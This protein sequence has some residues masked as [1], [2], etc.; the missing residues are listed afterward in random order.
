[1]AFWFGLDWLLSC[2]N[3]RMVFSTITTV[4]VCVFSHK[5]EAR[6]GDLHVIDTCWAQPVFLGEGIW[7]YVSFKK[8][9]CV[10]THTHSRTHACQCA[11]THFFFFWS[12][13]GVNF[14]PGLWML[15]PKHCNLVKCGILSARG[16]NAV[17]CRK[18]GRVSF[19]SWLLL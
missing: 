12:S 13:W 11:H 8:H 16:H 1:M 14:T 3:I 10:Y 2:C 4:C 9:S 18:R 6:A 15:T 5:A 19:F 17:S 7:E